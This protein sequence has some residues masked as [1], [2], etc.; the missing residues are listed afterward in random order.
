MRR[1]FPSNLTS[2]R[3]EPR[4]AGGLGSRETAGANDGLGDSR[5]LF[6]N[7]PIACFQ[8]DRKGAI[9]QWNRAAETLYGWSTEENARR[10][11]AD[12]LARPEDALRSRT[13]IE[14][15][16]AGEA[17]RELEWQMR[18]ADDQT[19][20]VAVDLFP[21]HD[22][23]D[24]V[25]SGICAGIDLGE[26]KRA[27]E[28]LVRH[29]FHDRLTNLPDR[30]LFMEKIEAAI[31]R[32][33]QNSDYEFAV[34]FLNLDR[35]KVANESLGHNAGDQLLI[36]TARKLEACIAPGDT[37]ARLSGDEF[38][39]L[40]DG[41]KGEDDAI[42]VAERIQK[43]L[44]LATNIGGQ[45]VFSSASIGVAFNR[46]SHGRAE[47]VLRDAHA[48]MDRAKASG[49]ARYEI[50]DKGLPSRAHSALQIESDLRRALG[51]QE[52]RMEYQPIVSLSTGL[53][54]GFEAL[55]RWNHPT[56]GMVPPGQ[57]I[58]LAEETGLIIP[59]GYWAL[60]EACSQ[61]AQWQKSRQRRALP[62]TIAVNLSAR[63]FSQRNL[64]E[65]ILHI[66]TRSGV[67]PSYLKLEITESAIMDNTEAAIETVTHLKEVGIKISLDDFGTGYSS[68]SYLHRFPFN[69]LK[70]DQAF[71]SRMD[72]SA[73]NEEIVR[74]VI[75]L[76][77]SL[78]MDVIAEGVETANQLA[79]LRALKCHYGQG[80]F[81]AAGMDAK[82]ATELIAANPQW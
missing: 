23:N 12:T 67:D 73:K 51:R 76:G 19:C 65:Q 58:P 40:L 22:E 27:E 36:S 11:V 41:I 16:F 66:I 82:T 3:I 17:I 38:A 53:I 60:R 37:V 72:V 18:C 4:D 10:S 1:L 52:L 42:Q 43:R 74:A 31:K 46:R 64:L 30:T 33:Q 47:E 35:F 20:H 9:V 56:R 80:Y 68:L 44:A 15:V 7:L 57:F 61:L 78:S 63:Q 77:H 28:R 62:V 75:A 25:A 13:Q 5:E 24:R 34:F 54:D 70:I 21:L 79:H 59:I 69:V 45:E 6:Q 71:V 49:K 8:F 48:A 14:R 55:V 39:I 50:F 29:A 32:A 2:R 26:R 81:F